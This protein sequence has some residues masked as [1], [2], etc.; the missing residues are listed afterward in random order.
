METFAFDVQFV[1]VNFRC[2]KEELFIGNVTQWSPSPRRT[3]SFFVK[4]YEGNLNR[5][6]AEFASN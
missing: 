1:G 2:R 5:K 3:P 4:D 6:Y